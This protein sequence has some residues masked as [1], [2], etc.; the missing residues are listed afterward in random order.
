MGRQVQNIPPAATL[1][2]SAR[3]LPLLRLRSGKLAPRL[4]ATLTSSVMLSKAHN[5]ELSLTAKL[6]HAR[7]GKVTD[8]SRRPPAEQIAVQ[9]SFV[10]IR[11]PAKHSAVLALKPPTPN[12]A[13][14]DRPPLSPHPG[15][16]SH[17]P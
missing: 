2:M 12:P 16:V 3:F 15:K 6:S 4:S 11:S 14:L 8:Q 17:K 1:E 5:V 9:T 10:S 7:I 13:F